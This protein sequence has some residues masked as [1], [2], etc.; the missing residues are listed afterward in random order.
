M[1][2]QEN[3][4]PITLHGMVELY[5]AL[6]EI[7]KN[8]GCKRKVLANKLEKDWEKLSVDNRKATRATMAEI[9]KEAKLVQEDELTLQWLLDRL[10]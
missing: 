8:I 1:T 4:S 5:S 10:P 6:L 9:L 3:I 2:N 7:E